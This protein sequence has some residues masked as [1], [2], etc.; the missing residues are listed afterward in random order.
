MAS[1]KPVSP[2]LVTFCD[3]TAKHCE[4]PSILG[5]AQVTAAGTATLKRIL[6]YG[7]HSI[8]AVYAGTTTYASSSSASQAVTLTGAQTFATISASGKAGNYTLT[9]TVTGDAGFPLSG[10]VSFFDKT[11][12][13]LPPGSATLG[14]SKIVFNNNGR[15]IYPTNGTIPIALATGDFNGDGVPDLAIAN[16]NSN[17]VEIQSIVGGE[18]N[19]LPM[20]N[21][22]P[23]A[24]AVADFNNDGK[25]DLAVAYENSNG[26]QILLG[27][28]NLQFESANPSFLSTGTA[29]NSIAVGDF[30]ND[31][32]VD[33]AVTN[34][35][36]A[37]VTI[38]L[39]NG[40]GEFTAGPQFPTTD[41]FPYQVAAGDFNLDGKQDLAVA[42]YFGNDVTILL[43][44]GNGTFTAAPTLNTGIY[45]D[46]VAV[47]DFNADGKPDLAVTN[48]FSQTV[49]ILLGSGNGTFTEAPASPVTGKN[50]DSVAVTD[51]NLDGIEDLV[52]A[53]SNSNSVTVF[54]G[55]GD[56]TFV[57]SFSEYAN[58]PYSIAVGDFA[59]NGYS[60]L[61]VANSGDAI[62]SGILH[63]ITTQA[64]ATISGIAVPGSGMHSVGA[65]YPGNTNYKGTVTYTQLAA[66]P[67]QTTT[68]LTALPAGPVAIG[69]TVSLSASVTPAQVGALKPTGTVSFYNGTALIGSAAVGTT[70]ST[71]FSTP[72]TL[73]L[74]AKYN[75]DAN[76]VA[77]KSEAITLTV[78]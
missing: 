52:V 15:I 41:S 56:G 16:S 55:N 25:P 31:G 19:L 75:G 40:R 66:S 37:N 63:S 32:N 3:A 7:T 36:S 44:N 14:A 10:K 23:Q 35:L 64:T 9:A 24:L 22:T 57:Q 1:G 39:G 26:V 13:N 20:T 28:G 43:G 54:Q 60:S 59:A 30:N 33:L 46:A 77:S 58:A 53:S 5:T 11:N 73:S 4:G 67:I 50:P 45:P 62:V 42:N 78:Q 12:N 47:G 21:Y 38:L 70:L 68:T 49:T 48:A 27:Q 65:S 8:K 6:S 61:A 2:G 29:P 72:G 17:T 69:Q 71:K 51:F 18:S 74:S 76:F 34:L